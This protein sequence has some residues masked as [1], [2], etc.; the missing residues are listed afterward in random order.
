MKNFRLIFILISATLLLF[1][2][3]IAMQFTEEVNWTLAD[4]ILAGV[5]LYGTGLV[6]EFILRKVK[7][8][9]MRIALCIVILIALLLIWA[10][11]AVGV[12]GTPFAG[13]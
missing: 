1:I 6:C 2:P 13:S 4:F 5:L 12:F 9:R 11:M 3:F 8:V 7:K 10:E